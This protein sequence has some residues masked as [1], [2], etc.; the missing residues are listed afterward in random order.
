VGVVSLRSSRHQTKSVLLRRLRIQ[1][2]HPLHPLLHSGIRTKGDA[3]YP[4]TAGLRG[5]A[6]L[7]VASGRPQ[8]EEERDDGQEEKQQ[9][10]QQAHSGL[11]KN[12]TNDVQQ[13]RWEV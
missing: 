6:A 12:E 11:P 10:E 7:P 2:E 4:V 5:V 13:T 3:V 8:L 9:A 1:G